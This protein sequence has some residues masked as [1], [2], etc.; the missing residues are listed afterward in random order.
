[1]KNAKQFT[2]DWELLCPD[3]FYYFLIIL[4]VGVLW[5]GNYDLISVMLNYVRT[6]FN[7]FKNRLYAGYGKKPASGVASKK[8]VKITFPAWFAFWD[9]RGQAALATDQIHNNTHFIIFLTLHDIKSI[10]DFFSIF[11]LSG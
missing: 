6:I 5:Q 1:M 2:V 9:G 11:F 4:A 3:I 7:N 8:E 10:C